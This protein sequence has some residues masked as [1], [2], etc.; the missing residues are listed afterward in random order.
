MAISSAY[1]HPH[2]SDDL[3]GDHD[4]SIPLLLPMIFAFNSGFICGVLNFG[5]AITFS[6]Q[7]NFAR[8]FGWLGPG[9]TFAKGVLFSQVRTFI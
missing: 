1:T 7:W 4:S 6:L 8:F 3:Q 2:L 9:T 5:Q